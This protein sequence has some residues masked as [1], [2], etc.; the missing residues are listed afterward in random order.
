VLGAKRPG[1][2]E[3]LGRPATPAPGPRET[4]HLTRAEIWC[5]CPLSTVAYRHGLRVSELCTL[6]WVS[7]TGTSS[8]RCGIPNSPLAASKTSGE[9][10]ESE[11]TKFFRVLTPNRISPYRG[12]HW[13]PLQRRGRTAAL[14]QPA[15]VARKLLERHAR[16]HRRH[17][18]TSRPDQQLDNFSPTR[19][20]FP[21]TDPSRHSIG[22]A[23][24]ETRHRALDC[25]LGPIPRT[26]LGFSRPSWYRPRQ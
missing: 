4:N 25:Q 22:A 3:R 13:I 2:A 21:Q 17:H 16:N 10:P 1:A 18:G 12:Q 19:R 6:R 9:R 11:V 26:L 7:G 5:E 20:E 8:T 14:D 23:Y 15:E 24:L